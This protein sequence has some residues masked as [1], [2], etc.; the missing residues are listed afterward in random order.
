V[1]TEAAQA[2]L[3]ATRR[4]V[5]S[6]C[7]VC[8][9]ASQCGLGLDFQPMDDGSVRAEF[10]CQSCHQG[11]NGLLHGGIIASLL[12]GAMTNC[13]FGQGIVAV[14]GEMTV[15]F[16][17]PVPA[18]ADLTVRAELVEAAEPLYYMRAEIILAGQVQA[19]AT[20]KFMKRTSP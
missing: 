12:D 16:C 13:L 10:R 14:T 17:R 19:R 20:A 4:K 9:H 7:V 11:Y 5:H 15:R 3:E 18:G 1:T 8:S 2:L 6:Q